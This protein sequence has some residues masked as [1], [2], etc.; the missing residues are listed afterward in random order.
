L[1]FAPQ[2]GFSGGLAGSQGLPAWQVAKI[3]S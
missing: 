2:V 3:S 1:T